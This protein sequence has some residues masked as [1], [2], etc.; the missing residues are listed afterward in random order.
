M[1][2]LAS[3]KKNP[4]EHFI[5]EQKNTISW[6]LRSLTGLSNQEPAWASQSPEG[7]L[8]P[9]SNGFSNWK[10]NSFPLP[11]PCS[12][13]VSLPFMPCES[14]LTCSQ[15]YL[16]FIWRD[17]V[18][19]E[20]GMIKWNR[21]NR[22]QQ[23]R[24]IKRERQFKHIQMHD[25]KKV[26]SRK[27][28]KCWKVAGGREVLQYEN[29]GRSRLFS[30]ARITSSLWSHPVWVI[31]LIAYLSPPQALSYC[32]KIY[33]PA[34]GEEGRE[35]LPSWISGKILDEAIKAESLLISNYDDMR[36]FLMKNITEH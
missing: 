2:N 16:L 5:S 13:C 8:S 31:P 24:V 27:Q 4:T 11:T 15:K 23:T 34:G 28:L 19:Q 26:Q 21:S 17:G 32:W 30:V 36:P 7:R 3:L 29:W 14:T 18:W 12:L 22:S 6:I 35:S 1:N 33:E 9:S 10:I 20:K 25:K